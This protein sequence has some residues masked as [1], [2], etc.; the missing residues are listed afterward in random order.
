MAFLF[1]CLDYEED[2]EWELVPDSV[3]LIQEIGEGAFGKV[4]EGVLA[5]Y[6]DGDLCVAVKVSER[7]KYK[8]TISTVN[9]IS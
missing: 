2:P 4:Y 6:E 1:L 3:E 5:T 9:V 7:K 8:K